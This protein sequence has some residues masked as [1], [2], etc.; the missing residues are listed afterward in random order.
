MEKKNKTEVKKLQP[1]K[2]NPKDSTMAEQ[3]D[4]KMQDDIREKKFGVTYT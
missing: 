1:E 2:V 3:I 4:K